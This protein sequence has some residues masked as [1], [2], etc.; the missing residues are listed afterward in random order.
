PP[1]GI[2]G[3]PSS[4]STGL[5]A[6]YIFTNLPGTTTIKTFDPNNASTLMA[7]LDQPTVDK[8]KVLINTIRG[9]KDAGEGDV[10]GSTSTCDYT[11]DG[12]PDINGCGEMSKKLWAI[13]HSTP[14]LMTDS[15]L[16]T[17]ADEGSTGTG[18]K[19]DMVIFAGAD[20][21]MLHA[22]HAGS[23]DTGTNHYDLGT[24]EEIWAYIPGSL[25]SSLQDQPFEPDPLDYSTFE[26]AVS[27]DGSPA[28]GDFLVKNT[29]QCSDAT[30]DYCWRTYLVGTAE[31]R[32]SS[33]SSL[34][35]GAGTI[36]ALDVTNPYSPSLLWE[37]HYADTSDSQCQGTEKNCN[38][39]ASKGVAIGSVF[40]GDE[41][42]SLVFLVSNWIEKK[43]P[44][45]WNF[46]CTANPD[47]T[48]C[49]EGIS[50]YALDLLTGDVYWET[51][52]PYTGDAVNVTDVPAIPALMDVDDNGTFDYLVFGDMQGRIWAL[53]TVN[54]KSLAGQT[55][56]GLEKPVFEVPDVTC[57]GDSC[58]AGSTPQGA[59]EPIGAPVSVSNNLVFFGTGGTDFAS[60]TR[61][62]H[63]FGLR[64]VS[65]PISGNYAVI[66]KVQDTS[67]D[68][69]K[70]FIYETE[71]GEKVWTKPLVLGNNYLLIAS[72]KEYHTRAAN[73][74]VSQLK[75][76]GRI[77]LLSLK[78]T[79]TTI[80]KNEE[81]AEW[82]EGGFVGGFDADSNHA[83]TISLRGTV[84]SIGGSTAASFT[85]AADRDNPFDI[86]WWRKL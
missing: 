49:V 68:S 3:F 28:L 80:L 31:V 2:S 84:Y 13:E 55:S 33:H 72:E 14:A 29:G 1:A 26:P 45:N 21:G 40:I 46:D 23:W 34:P 48:E 11:P 41:L 86:L 63:I 35:N 43:K 62:Y 64:I 15:K 37:G 16:V 66:H 65:T 20:D 73:P 67:T 4:P 83:Y 8:A 44:S 30:V 5:S 81:G 38:M 58:T 78:T 10:H 39:G 27:V 22:F 52:L 19:R 50:A 18:G 57:S 74:D 51:R 17:P 32:T 79:E 56:S 70:P 6:R 71:P 53:N 36:F 12:I 42:K 75:S 61:S 59:K 7:Y 54:G 25:L 24:G 82:T 76:E 77:G 69:L 60:N 85:P 47:D 9:R